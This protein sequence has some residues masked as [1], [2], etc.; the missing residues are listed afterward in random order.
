M[1]KADFETK[2]GRKIENNDH[3]NLAMEVRK[4]LG[5]G[6]SR[7]DN[8]G[9]WEESSDG[10]NLIRFYVIVNARRGFGKSFILDNNNW[11]VGVINIEL[12]D[13]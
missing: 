2:S 3:K 1:V 6:I 9:S 5:I 12:M 10:K 4:C 13:A 11:P 7:F 8:W